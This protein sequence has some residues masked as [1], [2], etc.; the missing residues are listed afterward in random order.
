MENYDDDDDTT[1]I[2]N[3]YQFLEAALFYQKPDSK[4]EFSVK[5]TN[6]FDVD[7]ISQNNVND[8]RISNTEYF[9]QPRIVMFSTKYNL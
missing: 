8:I 1:D 4:W 5:A 7:V 3:T 6:L 9:V 2:D